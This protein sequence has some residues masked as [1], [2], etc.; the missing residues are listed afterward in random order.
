MIYTRDKLINDYHIC[1]IE[2]LNN[3]TL[4]NAMRLNWL[5]HFMKY[6]N[7]NIDDFNEA[8]DKYNNIKIY[9]TTN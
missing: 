1:F 6:K 3:N 4:S 9:Q 8:S 7:F 5:N 2:S